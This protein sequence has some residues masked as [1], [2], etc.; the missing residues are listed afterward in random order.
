MPLNQAEFP[1]YLRKLS[2][3]VRGPNEHKGNVL[4]KQLIAMA[5]VENIELLRKDRQ[6]IHKPVECC[7]F[8]I[9]E[10]G[11]KYIQID[12]YGSEERQQAGRISQTIQFSKKA[13]KQLKE[14]IENTYL[15]L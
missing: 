13:A 15:D 5:L 10:S 6:S 7:A 14:M 2:L 4:E 12:T 11:E 9:S 1:T 3:I 8:V